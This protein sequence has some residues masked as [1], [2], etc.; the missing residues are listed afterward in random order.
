MYLSVCRFEAAE[1]TIDAAIR[2]YGPLAQLYFLMG[3]THHRQ[4]KFTTAL[5]ALKKATE[6]DPQHTEAILSLAVTLCDLG[7]YDQASDTLQITNQNSNLSPTRPQQALQMVAQTHEEN[8]QQYLILG[9]TAEALREFQKALLICPN[10]VELRYK[11]A[12]IYYKNGQ[13][14]N[15]ENELE[16]ILKIKDWTD[17]KILLGLI[18][19]QMGKTQSARDHWVRAQQMNPDNKIA[20]ALLRYTSLPRQ[21][22]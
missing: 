22:Q 7:Q 6:I 12:R 17:A 8:G 9:R 15:A 19:H 14:K 20:R 1:K 13:F 16:E 18:K 3:I 4:S 21:A 11:I 2:H 5:K 10:L